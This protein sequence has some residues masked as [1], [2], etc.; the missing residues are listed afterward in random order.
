VPLVYDE[1]IDFMAA[2][3][4]PAELVAFRPSEAVCERV[5]ELI[6]RE[7]AGTLGAEE[8]EELNQFQLLESIM[9]IAKAR[10]R[11]HLTPG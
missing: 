9:Q 5:A 2:G 1:M 11:K 6:R 3:M 7:K 10:A 8:T 4:T